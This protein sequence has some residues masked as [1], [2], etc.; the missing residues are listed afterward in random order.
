MAQN[1][2]AHVCNHDMMEKI[3]GTK[4]QQKVTIKTHSKEQPSNFSFLHFSLWKLPYF[5]CL[6]F[7]LEEVRLPTKELMCKT[8]RDSSSD[9]KSDKIFSFMRSI[10][11][12]IWAWD[13]LIKTFRPKTFACLLH[14]MLLLDFLCMASIIH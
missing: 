14:E 10:K 3:L 4:D 6:H 1:V 9:S 5:Y 12:A 2:S 8:R 7:G 13:P 11:D